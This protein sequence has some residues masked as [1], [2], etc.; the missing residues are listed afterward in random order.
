[1]GRLVDALAFVLLAA[2]AAAFLIGLG[3]LGDREELPALYL[4]ALGAC[5]LRASVAL[6]C[7]G[8]PG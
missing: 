4:M 7:P 3:G 2:T 6:L 5:A 1:M 8:G